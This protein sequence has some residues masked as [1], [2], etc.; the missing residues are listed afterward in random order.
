MTH[1]VGASEGPHVCP[2]C[3]GKGRSFAFIN[4]GPDSRSHRSGYVSCHT[5]KGECVISAE[6]FEAIERG[7]QLRQERVNRGESLHEAATK[8]GMTPAG[9]SAIETGRA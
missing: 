5:C 9:L 6:R 3:S 1:P 4:T 2:T 8:L 7:H